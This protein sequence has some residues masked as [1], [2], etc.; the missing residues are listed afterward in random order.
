MSERFATSSAT[1]P[2]SASLTIGSSAPLRGESLPSVSC[3]FIDVNLQAVS[4]TRARQPGHRPG[5]RLGTP[6]D[7]DHQVQLDLVADD[8]APRSQRPWTSVRRSGSAPRTCSGDWY[9]GD[10]VAYPYR[11]GARPKSA[12]STEP[13]VSTRTLLGFRSW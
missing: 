11:A 7:D 3:S 6:H 13:S 1:A 9:Q 12:T 10:D 4:A 8:P 2:T 5:A